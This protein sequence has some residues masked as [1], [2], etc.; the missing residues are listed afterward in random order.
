MKISEKNYDT[1]VSTLLLLIASTVIFRS[2]CTV[3]IGLLVLFTL[4]FNKKLTLSRQACLLIVLISSPFLLEIIFFWNNDSY[5]SGIKSLEKSTSLLLLPVVILGNYK[6]LHFLKLLRVYATVTTTI[7]AMFLIR[8]V[9]A[10]PALISKYSNGIDLWEMGYRFADSVGTHAPALNMHLAFVTLIHF[11]FIFHFIQNNK[12][13][14]LQ[15]FTILLFILSFFLVLLINTR[16]ALLNV[17]I[18]ILI[19]F[20]FEI[21]KKY[22][23]K[24][25]VKLLALSLFMLVTTLFFFIQN[26]PYMKEKYSTVTFAHM[27]KVGKLDEIKN[28]EIYVFNAAVTRLSIWK[29]TWELA[30]QNLP[31]GTGASD[32]KPILFK[33]YKQTNQQFLAK[34]EFPVHNQFLDFFL[35][36]GFLG[37]IV[38]FGFIFGI[39]CIGFDLKHSIIIA[40]AFLFFISNC[41]D[42]FLLR[43]DGI[44]FSGFWF[45]VFGSYW[46]Q[47]KTTHDIEPSIV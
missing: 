32:G 29:T 15:F 36:F 44:V 2:I 3:L 40:F 4:V 37:P 38:V 9:F 14:F 18:G 5:V 45:S 46:L 12:K 34:Y 20:F 26:N 10:Y 35:K 42:D 28:P 8:F 33:Y 24:K 39:T 16:I 22:A 21:S 41:T 7:I 47:N 17:L 1:I 30:V 19:I 23:L 27:D 43:F 11:Y 31:F 25:L 13:R 6:R